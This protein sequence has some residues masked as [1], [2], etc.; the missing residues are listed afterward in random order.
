[1]GRFFVILIAT[2][3]TGLGLG[4]VGALAPAP[5]VPVFIL[6]MEPVC[7]APVQ[8]CWLAFGGGN[9]VLVV[10]LA[11]FGLVSLTLYG[12]G[13]F[14]ATGQLAGGLLAI[15]QAGVGVIGWIGQVGAGTTGIGQLIFGWLVRGQLA[16][17]ADGTAFQQM[18]GRQLASAL[19]RPGS[20][21]DLDASRIT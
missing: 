15:G 12:A 10:G 20:S 14:F 7:L 9:G 13:L 6:G 4:A 18:L 21:Y 19:A 16:I 17:G 8:P 2:L 5:E 1:M 11:G 3:V